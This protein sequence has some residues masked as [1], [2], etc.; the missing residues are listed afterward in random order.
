MY[1]KYCV[2]C[3]EASVQPVLLWIQQLVSS[4]QSHDSVL[5]STPQSALPAHMSQPGSRPTSPRV[6]SP[7]TRTPPILTLSIGQPVTPMQG[8]MF[9]IPANVHAATFSPGLAMPAMVTSLQAAS[10]HTPM[11]RLGYASIDGCNILDSTSLNTAAQ[12]NSALNLELVDKSLADSWV[13]H[14][15]ALRFQVQCKLYLKQCLVLCLLCLYN[16]VLH[17]RILSGVLNPNFN[18]YTYRL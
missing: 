1:V 13:K 17:S 4:S 3:T 7:L 6:Q 2:S 8:T 5:C 14:N 16:M 12:E 18:L 15:D 9:A 10:L 11:S